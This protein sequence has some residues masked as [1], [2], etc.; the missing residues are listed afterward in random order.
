M[1]LKKIKSK[2]GLKNKQIKKNEQNAKIEVLAA[3]PPLKIESFE[4]IRHFETFGGGFTITPENGVFDDSNRQNFKD[5]GQETQLKMLYLYIVKMS[6]NGIYKKE[7][8]A[9]IGEFFG[10]GKDLIQTRFAKLVNDGYLI[11]LKQMNKFYKIDKEWS[12]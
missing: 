9:K 8:Y 6:D 7:G 3:I 2:L 1:K 12:A 10:V 4:A 5:K 11:E